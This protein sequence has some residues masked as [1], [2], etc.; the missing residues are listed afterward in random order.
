VSTQPPIVT[1]RPRALRR[2]G[3]LSVIITWLITRAITV[4]LAVTVENVA[5]GD[6]FYYWR[7][8]AALFDVGLGQTLNEYPTPVVWILAIP[9]GLGVGDR[10]AYFIVFIALML[11]LDALFSWLLWR[12]CGGRRDAA[13]DFWLFFVFLVG[14]IAYLRFDLVP[15]VLAG[16]SLLVSRR[17]PWLTGVLTGVGAAIKLWPALLIAPFLAYRK[18]RRAT[19][20]GFLAAGLGLALISLIFGGLLRLFSPLTWQSDRGLQIESVWAT[21]PMLLRLFRP[22][23]WAVAISRYQAFEVFG[24]GV[25][26]WLVVSTVATVVGF[27]LMVMLYVRA[28]RHGEPTT[29][30]I[31]LVVLATISLLIITNKTLS[32]QYLVWLGGPMAA[33]LLMRSRRPDGKPTMVSRFAIQLLVLALLTHLVYPL[34]YHGLYDDRYP[35]LLII[36]TVLLVIRNLGLLI[37][38]VAVTLAAWRATGPK[39]D[40]GTVATI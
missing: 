36:S 22:E 26:G 9:Y 39:P 3:G 38:T 33:L 31:G 34:T 24:P 30:A 28:F 17:Q 8:I 23:T 4:L 1:D 37:F 27:V 11:A 18:G 5:T 21:G 29:A 14:P 19:L 32:P 6:V 40:A 13:L 16:V 35:R 7:K 20:I 25:S 12:T 10:I 15:A 2:R